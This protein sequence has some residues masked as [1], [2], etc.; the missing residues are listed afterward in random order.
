MMLKSCHLYSMSVPG[1]HR[2]DRAGVGELPRTCLGERKLGGHNL[3]TS[4]CVLLW[5][6]LVCLLERVRKKDVPGEVKA[7]I[8]PLTIPIPGPSGESLPPI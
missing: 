8:L 6:E 2:V 1:I 4:T 7:E 5:G 3:S